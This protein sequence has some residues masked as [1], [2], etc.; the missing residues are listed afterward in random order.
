MTVDDIPK[1]KYSVEVAKTEIGHDF[2]G[3]GFGKEMYEKVFAQE[4]LRGAKFARGDIRSPAANSIRGDYDSKWL[5]KTENYNGIPDSKKLDFYDAQDYAKDIGKK[6]TW[7]ND[8][9]HEL[10]VTTNLGKNKSFGNFVKFEKKPKIHKT[11][12]YDSNDF[13]F[14]T[15]KK[16]FRGAT[17]QKR[18]YQVIKK[19]NKEYEVSSYDIFYRNRKDQKNYVWLE[20]ASTSPVH[21]R[22]KVTQL[23]LWKELI[24]LFLKQIENSS[25]LTKL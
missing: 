25:D 21:I 10:L 2:R 14:K 11:K 6:G 3:R 22:N 13:F 5:L 1:R 16:P 12:K 20:H 23:D 17:A 8:T 24:I 4:R 7:Y 9:N 18:K 19:G 15:T